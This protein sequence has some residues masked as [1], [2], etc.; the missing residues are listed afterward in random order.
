MRQQLTERV[1]SGTAVHHVRKVVR[2]LHDLLPRFVDVGKALR[3]LRQLLGDVAAAEHRLQV[4]PEVLDDQPVL[5]DLRRR[6]Q[7]RHPLLDLRL[8]RR[9]V[10]GVST[11]RCCHGLNF[12]EDRA[13]S[14]PLQN[15]RQVS[16]GHVQPAAVVYILYLYYF[17][18]F[19]VAGY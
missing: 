7:L 6:R 1:V 2:A 11:Y 10:P 4:D 15:A 3:L 5:D 9:V 18:C 12:S 17:S 14:T 13:G 8:E 16:R 19:F